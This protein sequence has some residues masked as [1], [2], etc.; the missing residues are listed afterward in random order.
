MSDRGSSADSRS[1]CAQMRLA[2]ASS[3]SCPRTTMRWW[4]RRLRSCSSNSPPGGVDSL[5]IT[6]VP[7][8]VPSQKRVLLGADLLTAD[9]RRR[10]GGGLLVEICITPVED[11]R[12]YEPGVRRGALEVVGEIVTLA[13]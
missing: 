9:D 11:V 13:I 4:R 2:I 10:H 8:R 12:P 6:T 5:M 3:T 1:S 7:A